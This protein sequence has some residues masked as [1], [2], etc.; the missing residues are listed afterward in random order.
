MGRAKLP[1]R[2]E[3]RLLPASCSPCSPGLQFHCSDLCPCLQP[4]SSLGVW[5]NVPLLPSEKDICPWIQSH[6]HNLAC[7]PQGKI[8][9][10][11]PSAKT[12]S[13]RRSHYRT[14]GSGCVHVEVLFGPPWG[15]S[16][17]GAAEL[18]C[19][20]PDAQP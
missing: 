12:L 4:L 17:L 10:S 11:I 18:W 1:L 20:D 5:S 8:L 6:L 16:T 13:P 7:S 19:W 14:W 3:G 15:A 9:N 2:G